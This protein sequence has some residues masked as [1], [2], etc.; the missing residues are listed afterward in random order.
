MTQAAISFPSVE[1]SLANE[2]DMCFRSRVLTVCEFLEIK[3]DD[4]LLDC[5]CGR[6]FYLNLLQ[7]SLPCKVHAI[8]ADSR[9]VEQLKSSMPMST[10][11][12]CCADV[13]KLPF[14]DSFFDKIIFSEV[15]EHISDDLLALRELFRVLKPGGAIALTV[16]NKRYPFLWD[17]LNATREALGLAPIK[18][19]TFSGIWT[20]HQRLYALS[21]LIRL[22]QS[23]G[24]EIES[25]KL[26]TYY[27]FPFSHNLFYGFGKV[28]IDKKLLPN[29]IAKA[30]DRTRS[31]ENN[32]TLLNPINLLRKLLFVIDRL[33]NYWPPR[34]KSVVIALKLKKPGNA[35]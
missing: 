23:V 31:I 12:I 14:A 1:R 25:Q 5:G 10:V 15:L 21:D 13:T 35:S 22:V 33:N 34:G 28:L 2:L 7:E 32:G 20:N 26:L 29:S 30:A 6:G 9:L 17:P 8:D 24:F 4:I 11:S 19:G 18:Q 3:P 16:P 27:C